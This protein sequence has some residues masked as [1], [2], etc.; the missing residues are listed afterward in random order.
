MLKQFEVLDLIFLISYVLVLCQ[1]SLLEHTFYY[2]FQLNI[3]L[4]TIFDH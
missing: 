1:L 3:L 4:L 2:L